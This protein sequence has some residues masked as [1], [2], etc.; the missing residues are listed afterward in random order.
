MV[1]RTLVVLSVLSL[2]LMVAGTSFGFIGGGCNTKCMP[3]LY[4]PVDCPDTGVSKTIV[5]TW[6][7]KIEG[8]CPAPMPGGGGSCKSEPRPGM[9]LSLATAIGLPICEG[10][11]GGFDG[12]YGCLPSFGAGDSPCGSP[13]PG[14]LGGFFGAG[15]TMLSGDSTIFGALW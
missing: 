1:K 11:F 15:A 10:L 12:V 3:P 5:K 6:E 4:V 9:L 2:T 8:P 13:F 14:G 7:C